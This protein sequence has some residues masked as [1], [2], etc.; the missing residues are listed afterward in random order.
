MIHC[1]QFY[2]QTVQDPCPGLRYILLLLRLPGQNPGSDPARFLRVMKKQTV[3]ISEPR[4]GF[5]FQMCILSII[6]IVFVVLGHVRFGIVDMTESGTFYG[7]FPYYSFHL[8]IFL[9]ITGYFFKDPYP[10][11]KDTDSGNK[12]IGARKLVPLGRFILH[13]AK[14]LLLPFFIINGVFL[15]IGNLL[16]S[17]GFTWPDTFSFSTWLISPWTKMFTLTLA[18]PTWYLIALFIAEIYFVLIRMLLRLIIRNSLAMEIVCLLVCLGMGVAVLSIKDNPNLGET[19][20]VYL[21]SVLMLFFMQAGVFYRRHM[22]KHDNLGSL[23]YFGIVFLVQLGILI[24]SGDSMLSPGLY[25]LINF[26]TLGYDYFLA[27]FNGIA[28][29]LRISRLIASVP[30]KKNRFLVFMGSNT[31]Y[32]MSFHV[33]GFFL[34]NAVCYLLREAN[35]LTAFLRTFNVGRWHGYLYY[36][37]TD[38]PRMILL[39]LFVG[40]GVSL[41]LAWIIHKCKKAIKHLFKKTAA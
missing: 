11:G 3:S 36:T 5:N 22:E 23:A 7:W 8:P 40:V 17:W 33:L 27:G 30:I 16:V 18:S 32:I 37:L 20:S 4:S 24:L 19:V 2:Y 41:G 31:L 25:E 12:L 10:Y 6:A 28:L 29:Y 39:Y 26:E 14:T 38:N 35:L 34:L 9:F 1:K 13:K 15:L 21:R